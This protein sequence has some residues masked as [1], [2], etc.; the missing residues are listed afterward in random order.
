MHPLD[1]AFPPD[2]SFTL[3]DGA[4]I[5]PK[6]LTLGTLSRAL[7]IAAPLFTHTDAIETLANDGAT[8]A[9][10]SAAVEKLLASAPDAMLDLMATLTDAP[11]ATLEA[12][13]AAEGL[14]LAVLVL[15]LNAAFFV[16]RV[17]PAISR[18]LATLENAKT[19]APAGSTPSLS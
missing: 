14:A 10:L 18:A 12:L 7:V 6:E 11:R 4:A 16:S 2:L 19:Q 1:T 9:E 8:Y 15:Q 3:P 13:P 17:L 5:S